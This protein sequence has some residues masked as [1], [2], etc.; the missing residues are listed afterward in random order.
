MPDPIN[1][2]EAGDVFATMQ[3]SIDPL[4][5]SIFGIVER[6]FSYFYLP[7]TFSAM[8]FIA[9]IGYAMMSGYI[10]MSGREIAVKFSKVI[11][12]LIALQVF[13][14]AAV[15][16]YQFAWSV[17]DSLASVF[18]TAIDSS[19]P[20]SEW[21]GSP[22]GVLV[23]EHTG[24]STDIAIAYTQA[25]AD[26]TT[27]NIIWMISMAPLG[28]I[29]LTY[30]IAKIVSA[31]LFV[32]APIV[33]IL[34]LTS[35]QTPYIMSWVKALLVTLVTVMLLFLLGTIVLM[36]LRE[37]W[38]EVVASVT[39]SGNPITIPAIYVYALLCLF[40]VVI[41]GQC[42]SIASSIIGAAAINTQQGTSLMQIAALNA[43]R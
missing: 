20:S 24:Y 21:I 18:V 11:L 28:V 36:L 37:Q 12:V 2:E 34:S 29:L 26:A 33:L 27:T 38:S 42:T 19:V 13:S 10:V 7:V 3:N 35:V 43:A 16:V 4:I 8:I 9:L 22:F 5:E 40:G 32:T 25:G 23:A 17:P 6:V 30:A 39:A 1:Y 14:T 31:A 41:V 15:D